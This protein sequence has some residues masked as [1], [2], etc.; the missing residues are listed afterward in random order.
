MKTEIA[1]SMLRV[2]GLV[3]SFV[4]L[5]AAYY[6]RA[7]SSSTSKRGLRAFSFVLGLFGFLSVMISLFCP[8]RLNLFVELRFWG[9]SAAVYMVAVLYS[10]LVVLLLWWR[11]ARKN[12]HKEGPLIMERQEVKHTEFVFRALEVSVLVV[13]LFFAFHEA[14]RAIDALKQNTQSNKM[15]GRGQ[16]YEADNRLS[17]AESQQSDGKL[18]TLYANSEPECTNEEQAKKYSEGLLTMATSDSSIIQAKDVEDLYAKIFYSKSFA[19]FDR[20][21]LR[22][23]SGDVVELRRMSAHCTRILDL[24][25][26]AYDY[27]GEKVIPEREFRTWAGYFN[28]IGPHPVF[29]ATLWNWEQERYMSKGFAK[30]V[31]HKLYSDAPR[32]IQQVV[33]EFYPALADDRYGDNLP[34]YGETD[35][36]NL[37]Q[38]DISEN[39]KAG[40]QLK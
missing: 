28:D 8:E 9:R 29:L 27:C 20:E 39:N 14:S 16:L 10:A 2:V 35:W 19:K 40:G 30:Y 1:D 24:L 3:V 18:L 17:E 15:S 25:H 34:D 22:N 33:K 13:G 11:T 36:Q 26:A 23:E 37:I 32:G 31:H 12:A 7:E 6:F 21:N 5:I 4:L 38:E